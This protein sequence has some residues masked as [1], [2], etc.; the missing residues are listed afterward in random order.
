M[1][2]PKEANEKAVYGGW[3]NHPFGRGG[4]VKYGGWYFLGAFCLGGFLL[5][6]ALIINNSL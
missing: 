5:A 3:E 4:M 1:K 6:A 2:I